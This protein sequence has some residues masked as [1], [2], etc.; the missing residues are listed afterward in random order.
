MACLPA[1]IGYC[2]T[3]ATATYYDPYYCFTGNEYYYQY[4]TENNSTVKVKKAAWKRPSKPWGKRS[5]P[6]P[7]SHR[8]IQA[9]LGVSV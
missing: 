2:D 7:Y 4:V 9:E 1:E 8:V 6:I 5:K 3:T